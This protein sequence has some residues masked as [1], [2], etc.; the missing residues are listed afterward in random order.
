[1]RYDARVT[2]AVAKAKLAMYA[3]QDDGP[4][5]EMVRPLVDPAGRE[6]RCM[7]ATCAQ[8]PREDPG[9][10]HRRVRESRPTDRADRADV[11]D[12]GDGGR[13][14]ASTSTTTTTTTTLQARRRSISCRRRQDAATIPLQAARG[15]VD[16][17]ERVADVDVDVDV[18]VLL[19]TRLE[20][21]P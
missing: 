15:R 18:D 3:H 12:R 10:P 13:L 1:M 9:A 17:L 14:S 16:G 20:Q 2:L 19:R 5:R 8:C 11:A 21:Q 6:R 7:R 4:S